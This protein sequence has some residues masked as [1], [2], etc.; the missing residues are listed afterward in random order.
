MLC[1]GA[2]TSAIETE[3]NEAK[4]RVEQ[5]KAALMEL[6]SNHGGLSDGNYNVVK[7]ALA[8]ELRE[9]KPAEGVGK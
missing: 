4:A 3:L 8:V 7:D 5:L 1:D 6:E 2:T 9:E